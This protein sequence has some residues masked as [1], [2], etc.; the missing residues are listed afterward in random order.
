[1][2]WGLVSDIKRYYYRAVHIVQITTYLQ[3]IIILQTR[4][5]DVVIFFEFL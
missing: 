3:G 2:V 1:M 4:K 5:K